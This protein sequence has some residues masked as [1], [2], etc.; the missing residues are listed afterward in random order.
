MPWTVCAKVTTFR[1]MAVTPRNGVP[2]A[3]SFQAFT[4]FNTRLYLIRDLKPESMA[5]HLPHSRSGASQEN[6]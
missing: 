3:V 2:A 1:Y 4:S 5:V 6:M